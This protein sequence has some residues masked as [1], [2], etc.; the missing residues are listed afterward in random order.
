MLYLVL[1]YAVVVQGALLP[2]PRYMWPM[3]PLL[4]VLAAR[5]AWRLV[6]PGASPISGR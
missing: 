2:L 4:F 5:T 3:R 1:A 6:T